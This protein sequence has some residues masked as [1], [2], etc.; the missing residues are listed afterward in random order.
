MNVFDKPRAEPSLLVLCR[1]EK[2]CLKMNVFDKPRAE[3]NLFELCRG[4]KTATKERFHTAAFHFSLSTFHLKKEGS[5]TGNPLFSCLTGNYSAAA[6]VATSA[7]SA[8]LLQAV[9]SQFSSHL[10]QHAFS[11]AAASTTAPS[12]WA[13]ADFV[14]AL[15]QQLTMAAAASITAKEKNFFITS[16]V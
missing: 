6:S 12:A 1:G 11:S 10:P 13:S 3:P 15:P 14:L 8:H 16:N 2:T 9:E 4:E 7:V 5:P